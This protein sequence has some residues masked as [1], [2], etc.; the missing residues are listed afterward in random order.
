MPNARNPADDDVPDD[1]LA[2]PSSEPARPLDQM[3]STEAWEPDSEARPVDDPETISSEVARP[4]GVGKEIKPTPPPR[5]RRGRLIAIAVLVVAAGGL[6]GFGNIWRQEGEQVV[7]TPPTPN[8]LV[9]TPDPNLPTPSPPPNPPGP[10]GPS[11]DG[12]EELKVDIQK[13]D[14][15]RAEVIRGFVEK[16]E[17]APQTP[18]PA[19]VRECLRTIEELLKTPK[20]EEEKRKLDYWRRDLQDVL[21]LISFSSPL[22]RIERPIEVITPPQVTAAESQDDTFPAV[23]GSPF[24][25]IAFAFFGAVGDEWPAPENFDDSW[26]TGRLG[27]DWKQLQRDWDDDPRPFRRTEKMVRASELARDSLQ[28]D[29]CLFYQQKADSILPIEPVGEIEKRKVSELQ[30]RLVRLKVE[31]DTHSQLQDLRASVKVADE[32]LKM[33]EKKLV[34]A[35]DKV[36]ELEKHRV[37]AAQAVQSVARRGSDDLLKR[38]QLVER[39]QELEP[40]EAAL[41][42][43]ITLEA[44]KKKWDEHQQQLVQIAARLKDNPDAYDE[45]ADDYAALGHLLTIAQSWEAQAVRLPPEEFKRLFGVELDQQLSQDGKLWLLKM[46]Q[47]FTLPTKEGTLVIDK[48]VETL[49][50]TEVKKKLDELFKDIPADSK[51]LA[52]LAKKVSELLKQNEALVKADIEQRHEAEQAKARQQ[53][54]LEQAKKELNQSVTKASDGWNSDLKK[55]DLTWSERLQLAAND[56]RKEIKDSLMLP[57]PLPNEQ[58]DKMGD[59]VAASVKRQLFEWGYVPPEAPPTERPYRGNVVSDPDKASA[60]FQRGYGAYLRPSPAGAQDAVRH[61]SMACQ[62]APEVALYRYYLG[63]AQHRCGDVEAGALQVRCGAE[64]ELGRPDRNLGRQLE[65]VQGPRRQWLER[66]RDSIHLAPVRLD[67][68]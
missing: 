8:P 53:T 44:R 11:G 68:Q 57:R 33:A 19:S 63:L 18:D 1:W 25:L 36:G 60:C 50:G 3:E 9:L 16:L 48:D 41:P 23:V 7:V 15:N 24:Y 29:A 40:K 4:M 12:L 6:W 55:A 49:A 56:L 22:N 20:D 62:F 59:Q 51:V 39:W 65:S 27:E 32:K 43:G 45:V 21:K 28:W 66:I 26:L 54:A 52:G 58:V 14:V 2:S 37:T 17:S 30:T 64:L 67:S 42:P 10:S 61:F 5:H 47:K 46:L 34:G 13:S 31:L 38:H 35:E